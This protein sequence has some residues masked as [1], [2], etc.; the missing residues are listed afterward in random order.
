MSSCQFEQWRFCLGLVHVKN[1]HAFFGASCHVP[2]TL[3]LDHAR[4]P[5]RTKA[6]GFMDFASLLRVVTL[7]VAKYPLSVC[8]AKVLL[9]IW[10]ESYFD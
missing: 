3:L 7:L 5:L 8:T 9:T 1:I 10:M 4:I 6:E 2:D